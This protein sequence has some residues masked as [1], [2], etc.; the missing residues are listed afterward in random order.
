MRDPLHVSA[1][2]CR[3]LHTSMNHCTSH[4]QRE[5]NS[6]GPAYQL[7]HHLCMQMS[8]SLPRLGSLVF[9]AQVRADCAIEDGPG[10]RISHQA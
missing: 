4:E 3:Q 10:I 6:F 5:Q 7:L 8:H 1:A 9:C 2:S